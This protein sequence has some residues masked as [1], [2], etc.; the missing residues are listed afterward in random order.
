MHF[1][2]YLRGIVAGYVRGADFPIP[3]A[4]LEIALSA[5]DPL[6]DGSGLVEPPNT[7][8]YARQPLTLTPPNAVIGNGT[9]SFNTD[10]IIFGPV[11]NNA[12]PTI[13]HVAVFDDSGNMLWHGPLNAQRTPPVGDELPF[14]ANALQLQ[15]SSYFGHYFG[16]IILNWMRGVSPP[17]APASTKLALS[18]ADPLEDGSGLDEPTL[19]Y[20]RQTVTFT[21]PAANLSGTPIVSEG[22]YIFGPAGNDWGLITYSALFTDSGNLLFKGP[23]AV[24]RNVVT[25]DS[26][27]VPFGA[28]TILIA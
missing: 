28:L 22:P 12:W 1:S 23:V 21:A 11:A 25:N 9:S 10:P 5:G 17:S 16:N 6:A 14:A 7:D 15:V 18:I 20:T 2:S 19:N 8:G 24:Q 3:P 27:A 26:F 4:S 13:T